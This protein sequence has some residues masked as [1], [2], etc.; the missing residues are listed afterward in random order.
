MRPYGLWTGNLFRGVV[1]RGSNPVPFAEVE[2]E[3]RND[4]SVT[5]PADACV[6][7]VIRADAQGVFAY[8]YA[9]PRRGWWGFTALMEGAE[10]MVNP[11]GEAVPVEQDP[12]CGCIP[13]T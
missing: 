4:D 3:W 10:T 11:A 2:V 7:Q 6:T 1:T 12:S 8:A 9:M 5:P 13:G